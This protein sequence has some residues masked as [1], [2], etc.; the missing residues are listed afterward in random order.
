M[1]APTT[2]NPRA[3]G[4][5]GRASRDRAS[6]ERELHGE[7]VGEDD[8]TTPE[9]TAEAERYSFHGQTTV[10]PEGY[11]N[12]ARFTRGANSLPPDGQVRSTVS[13][14]VFLGLRL[15]DGGEAYVNP[16]IDQGYGLQSTLGV[17]GFTSAEAYKVG[18]A[19]PYLRFQRHFIRQTI[20]LGG[21]SETIDPGR[22]C[23]AA[24]STQTD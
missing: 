2:K 11:P 6:S 13:N 16:E 9:D 17:A 1:R 19:R 10:P 22:I 12:R 14:T 18:H 24:R 23:S 21:E 20:G 5:R 4:R 7:P 15:W 8:P 3:P